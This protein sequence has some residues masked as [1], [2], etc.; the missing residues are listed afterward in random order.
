[1]D[2][3]SIVNAVTV[4][5]ATFAA[6]PV[7][8]FLTTPQLRILLSPRIDYQLGRNN[9]LMVRYSFNDLDI[10]NAGIGSFDQISRGYHSGNLDHTVQMTETAALGAAVNETRFQ[11]FRNGNEAIANS[12]SP[13]ILVLGAFN[14]GGSQTGNSRT[15]QSNY[16]LQ[17]YTSTIRGKHSSKFGVRFREQVLD[18]LSPRNFGGTFTFG[19]GIAPVLDAN[20]QPVMVGGQTEMAAIQPIDRYRRALLFQQMGLSAAQAQLLGG[21]PTQFSIT[22]GAPELSVHQAD[23][24]VFAGDDWRARPNLTVSMGLRYEAQTN[25]HDHRDWAP[26]ISLAWGVGGK[27]AKPKFVIRTGFGMFYDRFALT[28]T[29]TAQRFGGV[30]PGVEQQYVVTNPAFYP[31]IPLIASLA[32]ASTTQVTQEV[33]SRFRSPYL[34][35]SALSVERQLISGTTLAV[36]YSNSHGLHELRSEDIDAPLP[37]SGLY[38]SG[39][40]NPVFLMTSSGLYNQNQLIFNVNSRV[41]RVITLAGSYTLNRALSNTDGLGTFPANPY[42]FTGEY[43]PASSDIRNRFNLTGSINLRWHIR[44]SPSVNIQS[45][46]PFDITAGGDLYG[47]TLFNGRPGFATDPNKPGLVQ[48]K[49]GLLDPNPTPDERL[50]PRNFGRGPGLVTVNAR[51]GKTW[52]FGHERGKAPAAVNAPATGGAAPVMG[53]G[54]VSTNAGGITGAVSNTVH[55]YNATISASFRNLINHNNPGPIVGTITSPLFGEAN[56]SAGSG[57][58]SGISEAGN[59]RRLEM[60]FRVTF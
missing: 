35:Q 16:E 46:A 6:V 2:N 49:Y 51:I 48:T 34:M 29:L 23:V 15:T 20:N 13:A 44:I 55:P 43:G 42:S 21:A 54:P 1:V 25:I 52:G 17:N 12:L 4:D 59:N 3:G 9:T 10:H 18:S 56:Q 30:G 53:L 27:A 41:S 32:G 58:G 28:N 11:Y 14:G 8:T 36:T 40:P 31:A 60:Q 39:N 33:S 57:G 22:A 24:G 47:T 45:G 50:V 26:R 5:P 19:G 37:V 7:N 38:S